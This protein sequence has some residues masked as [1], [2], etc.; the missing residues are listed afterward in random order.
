MLCDTRLTRCH[1]DP[2]HILSEWAPTSA[3]SH[4]YE[5]FLCAT[6]AASLCDLY[7]NT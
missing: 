6:I 2:F 5:P 3:M 1:C 4:D 7:T